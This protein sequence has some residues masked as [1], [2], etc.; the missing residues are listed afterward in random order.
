M[1][2]RVML[3]LAV[4]VLMLAHAGDCANCSGCRERL[5]VF[6][7]EPLHCHWLEVTGVVEGGAAEAVGIRPGDIIVSYNGVTVGC[8]EDLRRVKDK[9]TT[10]SVELML[11]RDVEE[12][13]INFPAGQLGVYLQEWQQDIRPDPDAVIIDGIPPLM[14]SS[15][16]TGTFMAA[17]E[18]VVASA[19]GDADYVFLS[20]VSGA[21]FRTHFHRDWCPSSPD[22]ACGYDATGPALAACGYDAT[23]YSV[24]TDG[25][26]KPGILAAFMA[27]IDSGT[28]VLAVDLIELPEWG[29]IT[30]YQKQGEELFCRTFFDKRKGYELARNFPFASLVLTR[31]GAVPEPAH[32]YFTSFGI[33]AENLSEKQ[34]GAYYSGL[35]AFDYWIE[36]LR[37]DDFTAMDS[38]TLSTAVQANY[39]TF[40]RLIEDRRTGIEYLDRVAA[41]LPH[42]KPNLDRLTKLYGEEVG[43]LGPV[44]EQLPCPGT[45]TK[46]EQ[47]TRELRDLQIEALAAARAIEEKAL[48][49]WQELAATE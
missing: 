19:G 21:A 33:V 39:W 23:A 31:T 26:N 4:P 47:W 49:A 8:L 32:S 9:V 45:C 30:G 42:L 34:Y 41:A 1:L 7:P 22:P 28:P 44:L 16:R 6:I 37:T 13:V 12:L 40:N 20:G 25:K 15:G 5:P 35:A 38:A 11:R 17:L 24:S 18:A 10:D 3:V 27:S 48:P 29:I 36:Q 43:I 2:Y 14:W 46:A